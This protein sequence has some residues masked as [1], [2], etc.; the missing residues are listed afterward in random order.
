MANP[1][2]NDKAFAR[3]SGADPRLAAEAAQAT[4]TTPIT[5]GPISP[6]TSVREGAMTM[7][8]AATATGVLFALLLITGAIG[9]GLVEPAVEGQPVDFPGWIFLV[10]IGAF[11]VAMV[12][13]FKPPLAR[14]LAPLYALAQGLVLGSI[15]RLYELYWNGIVVMAIGATAGVFLVTFAMYALRL[16]RVTNRFRNVVIA[17]TFG[18][19]LFYLACMLFSLFGGNVSFLSSSSGLS[20]AFSFFAAGIAAFNLFLDFDIIERGVRAG[21]PKYMEWYG[22]LGLMITLVWLYLEMLRLLSKLRS[23]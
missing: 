19:L 14:F 4:R 5:D 21:A 9:W 7:G 18:L 23:R 12:A 17:A 13:V 1:V 15:S 11:V 20:I 8:G 6:Y 22:A 16:V 2:L 10:S 3:E